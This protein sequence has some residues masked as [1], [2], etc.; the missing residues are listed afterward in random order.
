V[1]VE[2]A[3][4]EGAILQEAIK[5]LVPD[6][7][8]DAVKQEDL[9]VIG[10]P[11][12]FNQLETE[13]FRFEVT[14]PLV[15]TVTL[16]DYASVTA[17]RQPV[18]V[19]DEEVDEVIERLREREASWDVPD[20]PRPAQLGDQLVVDI[21]DIVADQPPAEVQEDYTLELGD[22]T[23]LPELEAQLVGAEEGGEYEY[24]VTLPEDHPDP[25]AAGKPATFKV[26]VK[27]IKEKVR[28][29]ID[30]DFA[31]RVGEGVE[32][33]E[34]L[35]ARVR[36]NLEARKA[37]EERERLVDDVVSKLVDAS[38]VE[39]PDV[40]V[41]REVEHRLE[42]LEA[43]LRSGGIPLDQYLQLTN[44]T[45]DD[46]RNELREPARQR[47]VRGLVLSE[48]AK[49]EGVE[50]DESDIDQEIARITSGIDESE[51]ESARQILDSDEW[52]RRMRS[53]VYDRKVLNHV[54]QLATGEPL[55]A[56]IVESEDEPMAQSDVEILD[57]I[58]EMDTERE[59][60]GS[61]QAAPD[62]DSDSASEETPAQPVEPAPEHQSA[63]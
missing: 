40:M 49:A 27:S 31:K 10:E 60:A 38:A 25:E 61:P 12:S 5:E 54:V 57:T 4:G 26:K 55:D 19:T 34:E 44:R 63:Q 3:L 48:V 22:G 35:R 23:V 6:A 45:R 56:Q 29:E 14:V 2:R 51:L 17:E 33:V 43:E 36:E 32:S 39:V 21:Q 11:E 50:V 59:L 16:G 28:P 37:S 8:A 18:V 53:D 58:Q 20:P 62:E 46:L 47:L 42:H 7:I 52:R 30:D 24:H 41:E 9:Q 15:P 1:L 13:P